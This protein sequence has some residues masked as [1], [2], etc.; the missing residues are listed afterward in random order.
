MIENNTLSYVQRPGSIERVIRKMIAS[1]SK[2]KSHVD[3]KCDSRLCL[4]WYLRLLQS[5]ETLVELESIEKEFKKHDFFLSNF[6]RVL[7]REPFQE[8]KDKKVTV[9]L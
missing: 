2:T 6:S 7:V 8:N 3:N 1:R 5:S 9:H 4:T